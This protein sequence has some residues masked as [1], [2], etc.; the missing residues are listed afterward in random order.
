[1]ISAIYFNFVPQVLYSTGKPKV[2][3]AAKT[4]QVVSKPEK[5]LDAPDLRDD[6]YLHLIDWSVNNELAVTLGSDVFIW[7]APVSAGLL[8]GI[9]S[10]W[11]F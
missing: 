9:V 8:V 11:G 4:R 7:N 2:A 6:F 5:I 3:S 10:T 1:M